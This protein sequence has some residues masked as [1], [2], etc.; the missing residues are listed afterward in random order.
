VRPHRDDKVLTAWN[1]LMISAYAR[2]ARVLG[3]PALRERAERAAAFVWTHLHDERTGDL[4][5]RWRDGEAKVPGQLD[6]YAYLALGFADLYQASLDPKWLKR[7]RTLVEGMTARF[8]DE[9]DGAFFE[10]PA[11]DAHLKVRMKDGFDGAEMAGNSIAALDLQLL[12]TL[13][14]R[15][16]WLEQA[17][18]T[19]DYFARRLGAGAAAMPQMLVAM[20]LARA[21]PRHIVV[22]GRADAADTRALIA[23]F[24]GRFLPH[25]VLLLADGGERQK[26]LAMLAPFV[27]PLIAK[28]GRATAYVCVGYAC[29]LP[30][31]DKA[32]F[33]AQL[34][35]H[36]GAGG[37]R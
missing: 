34:D 37:G 33:A 4:S 23:E 9:R 17:R 18:R 1:G 29:R 21:T 10:S 28:D 25:D 20:D 31:T 3:E 11:G 5:R 30:T 35:E 36:T 15:R 16:D 2:G 22:A 6:D 12:G 14:D 26:A 7:A 8:W 19:F 27:G 13:L 32:A 24:D